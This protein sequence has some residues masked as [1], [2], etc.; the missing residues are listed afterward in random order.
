MKLLLIVFLLFTFQIAGTQVVPDFSNRHVAREIK[1]AYG[2][3]QYSL[4]QIHNRESNL[5]YKEIRQNE[6]LIGYV[7]INRVNSCRAGLCQ[8]PDKNSSEYFDYMVLYNHKGEVKSVKVFNYAA[9]HG[10]QIAS[11]GWL[12][13]F[14]GFKGD[15]DKQVGKNVDAIAGATISANAITEDINMATRTLQGFI[16]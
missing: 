16:D 4:R 12:R 11:P 2:T 1:K 8:V 15:D 6:T 14:L 10:Q 7:Y 3:D 13:Q 9:T 5:N